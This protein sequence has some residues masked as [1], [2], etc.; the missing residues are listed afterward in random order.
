MITTVHRHALTLI[1]L[2]ALAAIALA[3]S[4][5]PELLRF[6][7]TGLSSPDADVRLRTLQM[8]R[9]PVAHGGRAVQALIPFLTSESAD[10]R[11]WSAHALGSFTPT[12]LRTLFE[13]LDHPDL[14]VRNAAAEG[15]ERSIWP[16][17][18][19]SLDIPPSRARS[20]AWVERSLKSYEI[21]GSEGLVPL[22]TALSN[23]SEHVRVF[24]AMTLWKLDRDADLVRGELEIAEHD[25]SATVRFWARQANTRRQIRVDADTQAQIERWLDTV[26][27]VESFEL[28]GPAA[29]ELVRLGGVAIPAL[30]ESFFHSP[31]FP[32]GEPT[33]GPPTWI[34]EQL[35]DDGIAAL[36]IGLEHW[37]AYGRAWSAHSLFRIGP[38]ALP[39]MPAILSAWKRDRDG[40]MQFEPRPY[41]DERYPSAFALA[42]RGGIPLPSSNS[43]WHVARLGSGAIPSLITALDDRLTLVRTYAAHAL[44]GM[45]SIAIPALGALEKRFSD[46]EPLV[47]VAAAEAVLAIAP[48]GEPI[49]A[50]ARAVLASRPSK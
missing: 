11:A 32:I 31:R 29:R 7:L 15:I 8:T 12:S 47:R 20:A 44:E 30:I 5:D 26:Y 33:Y 23:S 49:V 43:A 41:W 38:A 46:P 28:G 39:A 3:Q 17:E 16:R 50:R 25:P 45:E 42:M 48:E 18:C 9:Y 34:L 35:G 4:P 1:S 40:R 6:W 22:R 14:A 10:E 27:E 19:G 36:T 2:F 13:A 37:Y 24:A 21:V